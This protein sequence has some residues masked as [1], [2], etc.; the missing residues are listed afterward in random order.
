MIG[1]AARAGHHERRRVVAQR[2]RKRSDGVGVTCELC[3]NHIGGL[4]RFAE[5]QG[6]GFGGKA[7]RGSGGFGG[8]GLP[9]DAGAGAVE[10]RTTSCGT[11]PRFCSCAGWSS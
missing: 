11:K 4:R 9:V 10:P 1:T 6:I 5:H 3:S 2:L 8:R 7:H